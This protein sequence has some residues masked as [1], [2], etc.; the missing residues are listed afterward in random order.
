M[1]SIK[2]DVLISELEKIKELGIEWVDERVDGET[3]EGVEVKSLK[4][5]VEEFGEEWFIER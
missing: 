3:N 1:R 4:T 2:I 5:L